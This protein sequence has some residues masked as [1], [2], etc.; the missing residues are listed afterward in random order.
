MESW[1]NGLKIDRTGDSAIFNVF[2]VI[3][4]HQQLYLIENPV[5][6]AIYGVLQTIS[7][8]AEGIRTPDLL[9]RSQTLYPAELQPH[10]LVSERKRKPMERCEASHTSPVVRLK[11]FE[12]PTFWFVAKHS[13]QLSYSRISLCRPDSYASITQKKTVGK[14]FFAKIQIFFVIGKNDIKGKGEKGIVVEKYESE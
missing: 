12:P 10:I 8:T 14:P 11:G 7:G 1:S 13:I 4:Q 2:Y 3:I 9:V 5:D 6:F